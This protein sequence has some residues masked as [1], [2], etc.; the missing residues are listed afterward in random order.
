MR[1]IL[2]LGGALLLVAALGG[3]AWWAWPIL[4]PTQ[5]QLWLSTLAKADAALVQGRPDQARILL[6]EP[7]LGL[8]VSGWLQ[9]EK[10]VVATAEATQTWDWT[11][12]S[13]GAAQAQ[14]PGNLEITSVHVWALLK[15]GRASEAQALGQKVLVGTPWEDLALQ[16]SV[17]ASGLGQ[18]DWSN[19]VQVL[20]QPSAESQHVYERLAGMSPEPN[21]RKNAL[22]V[23]LAQGNLEMARSHLGVLSPAQRDQAPFDRLQ[24][25]MAYDQG[26]WSR[27]AALLKALSHQKESQLVLADV[28]LHLGDT[29]P[30]GVIYDQWLKDGSEIPPSVAI[31]RATLALDEGAPGLALE[32]LRRFSE[33]GPLGGQDRVTLL[34]L[35]ARFRLGEVASVRQALVTFPENRGE[36]SLEAELLKGRLFP[37]L[38]S[39]PKLWSLLHKAP[40]YQPLA[41]RLAWLLL[42]DQDY[43]GA[44]R[45]LDL[46]EAALSQRGGAVPWWVL[47]LRA[48]TYGAEGRLVEAD[49]T[50]SRVESAWR[51]ASFYADWSLIA[52]VRSMKS[53]PAEREPLLSAA[54]ERLTQGLELLPPRSEAADRQRRS[55]WLTR[56]GELQSALVPLVTPARRGILRS[57]AAEDFRQARSLDPDNLRASFL[58]RQAEAP[59]ETP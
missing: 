48:M 41:E 51:T 10:R 38:S 22:L 47:F 5:P 13:T 25:L 54:L 39:V 58:L 33:Q 18:G 42:R 30:A 1:K 56:R 55:L 15:A 32:V 50:F 8:S 19:L 36:L 26:D 59:Q 34:D 21:L 57:A 53:E 11:L 35:E 6:E 23:A 14:Y 37:E 12:A 9:W 16:A 24:G 2:V 7:P 43:P 31:N 20:A 45:V 3:G 52:A 17:E 28:Y 49:Q 4:F 29:A 44:H 46:H 27:A 40:D